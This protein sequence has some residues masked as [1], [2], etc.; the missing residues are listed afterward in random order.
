MPI[1]RYAVGRKTIIL[2]N[3]LVTGVRSSTIRLPDPTQ[4]YQRPHDTPRAIRIH[5]VAAA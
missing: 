4:H 2:S 5:D 3:D 1:K